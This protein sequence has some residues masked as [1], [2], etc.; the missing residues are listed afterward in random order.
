MDCDKYIKFKNG[1]IGKI[2][3]DVEF[4]NPGFFSTGYLKITF[5]DPKTGKRFLGTLTFG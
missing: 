4:R 1:A 3:R 2:V 5:E